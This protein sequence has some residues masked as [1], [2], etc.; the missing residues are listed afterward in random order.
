V[1]VPA[2]PVVEKPVE[3]EPVAE[4]EEHVMA[5]FAAEEVE[6][7]PAPEAEPEPVADPYPEGDPFEATR[8]INLSELKF[9]RNYSNDD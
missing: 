1:A 3:A 6:E 8:R 7:E 9:G 4:I 2:A 5:A